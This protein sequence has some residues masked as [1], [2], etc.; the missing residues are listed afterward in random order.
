MMNEFGIPRI[1]DVTF[2]SYSRTVFP[3]HTRTHQLCILEKGE[4]V[5]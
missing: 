1:L 3:R 5:P 2:D 4:E